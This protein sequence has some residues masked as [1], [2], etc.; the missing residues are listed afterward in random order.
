MKPI[1]TEIR[2]RYNECDPMGV[3]H[4]SVYPV[5]FEIGRTEHLRNQGGL[6][7]EIEKNG[8]YFVVASLEIQYKVSAAYDDVLLL[9]TSLKS[10]SPARLIH[11][12][13]LRK[14]DCVHATATT[15]LACVNKK[16][17]LQRFPESIFSLK[18]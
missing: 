10:M 6:Y 5:W 8:F 3:A 14:N 7:A 13:T 2:V 17:T 1:T 12:Y 11:S 16:G 18:Q 9:D 4:H 15:T